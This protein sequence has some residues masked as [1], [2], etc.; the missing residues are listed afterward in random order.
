MHYFFFFFFLSN[1]PTLVTT[2]RQNTS[3]KYKHLTTQ[4]TIN[5]H[6][7]DV[8]MLLSDG[9]NFQS[10]ACEN[11]ELIKKVIRNQ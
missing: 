1:D 6:K 8:F 7:C 5:L 11:P 4:R 2:K 10:Q 9:G 3:N